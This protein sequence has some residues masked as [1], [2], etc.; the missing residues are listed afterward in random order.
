[1]EMPAGLRRHTPISQTA[2]K[3]RSSSSS[4]YRAGTLPRSMLWPSFMPIEFSQA[5]VLISWMKGCAALAGMRMR[6]RTVVSGRAIVTFLHSGRGRAVMPVPED[7]SPTGSR[8]VQDQIGNQ[9]GPTGLVHGAETAAVDGSAT[10]GSRDPDADQPVGEVSG[11]LAEGELL[12]RS[13]GVL[14]GELGTE[15]LVVL[16]Q[17]PDDQVVDREPPRSER[18]SQAQVMVYVRQPRHAVFIPAVCPRPRMIVGEEAPEVTAVAVVLPNCP[19]RPLRHVGPP[20]VPR[21]RLEQVILRS[22]GRLRRPCMLS[23]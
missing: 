8:R 3:P 16:Q 9:C 22:A 18:Q 21:V 13:G 7:H 6:F 10:V 11:N 14:D 1:M 4:Q 20:L 19:P 17:R 23:G 2:S 15:E 12:P 5:Q